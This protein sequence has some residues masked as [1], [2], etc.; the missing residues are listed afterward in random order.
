M[1]R[2]LAALALAA[3]VPA[4]A[5]AHPHVM[6]EANLEFVRDTAGKV[7]ELRHV[8]RFDELFSA[9]VQVDFDGNGDGLL[10]ADELEEVSKTVT[11]SIGEQDWFTDVRRGNEQLDIVPPEKISVDFVDGQVLM[12]FAAKLK[13]PA[14]AEDGQLRVSIS[15]PTYY[16]AMD[17]VDETAVQITGNGAGCKVDIYRPDFDKLIAD[18]PDALTEEFFADPAKASLSDQWMSWITLK[19]AQS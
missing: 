12:F 7:T 3:A 2:I 13:Q 8:W 5:H 4:T 9:M 6:V 15:D 18:N 16:V 11:V 10:S 19:C 1:K 14:N 17:I